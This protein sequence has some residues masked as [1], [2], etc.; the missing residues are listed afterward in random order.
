MTWGSG[1]LQ[2]PLLCGV[3]SWKSV[4]FVCMHVYITHFGQLHVHGRSGY[5]V[6]VVLAAISRLLNVFQ[7]S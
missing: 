3:S 1:F 7:V 4:L 5:L 6:F 2:D